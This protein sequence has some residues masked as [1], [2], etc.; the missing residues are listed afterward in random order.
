MAIF[1][2]KGT[3]FGALFVLLHVV[4]LINSSPTEESVALWAPAS[5][6]FLR[7][8]EVLSSQDL[9]PLLPYKGADQNV[10]CE[11]LSGEGSLETRC[12]LK[13][14]MFFEEDSTFVSGSGTL[15]IC[16][17][18][19]ISC[20]TPGCSVSILLG[21]DM[22]VGANSTIRSGSLWI[23]AAN[24]N[25]GDGATLNSSALGGK[26][27]S[28]ASG[29][30]IAPDGAGAGHGGRGACCLNTT[31]K[32]QR[33]VWGGDMYAWKTVDKPWS[34]GSSGGTTVEGKDLGGKGGGRVNVTVTGILV[35]NGS[36][37]ADGGSVGEKGGGGSGGSLYVQASRM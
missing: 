4:P 8:T 7:G 34:F 12:V 35:I 2:L 28:G 11:D 3:Y 13:Q 37:E 36:I 27:P 20:D 6:L 18:I 26:P 29:T 10:T 17:N 16:P 33:D 5:N 30:P 14:S 32:K 21:G 23:E 9:N 15:E 22:N 19:S 25:L 1:C 24:L 31:T